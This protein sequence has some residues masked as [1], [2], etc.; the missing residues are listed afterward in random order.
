[1]EIAGKCKK[2]EAV[3]AVSQLV[4]EWARGADSFHVAPVVTP[5]LLECIYAFKAS[6]P[7]VNDVTAGFSLFLLSTGLPEASTKARERSVVYGMLHGGQVAPSL[8]QLWKIVATAPQMACTL[9]VLEQNYQGYSTLLDVLLG[10]NHRVLLY[11]CAFMESF[12]YLKMEVEEQFG[13]E[14]HAALPLFQWYMQ[15]TMARFFNNAT[16]HG[17]NM[18]LPR[19]N[20]LIDIIKY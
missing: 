12:Q 5:E 16:V 15:L 3:V 6:S 8:D 14:I 17:A 19:V 18:R 11:F 2:K 10:V 7:D 9:I 13:K 1:L 4:E 20:D